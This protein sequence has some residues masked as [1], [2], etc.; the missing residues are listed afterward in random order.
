MSAA[1]GEL[2][3]V[4]QVARRLGVSRQNVQRIA[5]LLVSE[6]WASFEE[7][8]DHRGSPHLVLNKRGQAALAEIS[9]V[10]RGFHADLAC[11]LADS[12]IGAIHRGLRRLLEAL[13]ELER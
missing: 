2:L 6:N 11:R 1:S 5:D 4:P 3:T 8:P 13:N 12:D 9:K 10:A 7:N